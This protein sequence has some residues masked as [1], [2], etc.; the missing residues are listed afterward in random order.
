[1]SIPPFLKLPRELRATVYHYYVL[2]P[3]G[4][5]FD[6]DASTFRKADGRPLNLSLILTCRTIRTEMRYLPLHTNTF[7]F[8]TACSES[9]RLRA[10]RFQSL[11][12]RHLEE[13]CF[14]LTSA[15]LNDSLRRYFTPKIMARLNESYSEFQRLFDVIDSWSTLP[16]ACEPRSKL[17][18][19]RWGG[20]YSRFSSFVSYALEL[21]T[22]D[23]P[24][25]KRELHCVKS[26]LNSRYLLSCYCSPWSIPSEQEIVEMEEIA[27]LRNKSAQRRYSRQ[28]VFAL[29]PRDTWTRIKWRWSAAACFISFFK[30]LSREYRLRIRR[31]SLLEDHD[32]VGHPECHAGGLVPF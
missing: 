20:S 3:D 32:S 16:H 5:H 10:G 19:R 14:V 28:D 24:N 21:L 25:F 18:T 11:L 12:E 6:Y 2:E 1:M 23:F 8:A 4:Y 31:V 7:I 13:Q 29:C 30:T 9:E 26:L 22:K 15:R 27:S 17:G